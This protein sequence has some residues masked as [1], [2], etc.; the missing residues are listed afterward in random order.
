MA[1]TRCPTEN[2]RFVGTVH[3]FDPV[4]MASE[5]VDL[6]PSPLPLPRTVIP[7][8]LQI[9]E[10]VNVKNPGPSFTTCPVVQAAIAALIVASDVPVFCV[11]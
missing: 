4:P 1:R 2:W 5:V 8:L 9:R 6:P 10:P 11:E 3:T 7:D